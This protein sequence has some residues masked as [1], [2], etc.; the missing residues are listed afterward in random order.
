MD[1]MDIANFAESMLNESVAS[2]KP[3][4]FAAATDPDAPDVSDVDVPANFAS[5]ILLEGHWDKADID[6]GDVVIQESTPAPRLSRKPALVINEESVYKKH[7]LSEYKKKVSDLED[8]IGVMENM[9]MVPSTGSAAVNTTGRIGQG[10]MGGTRR[11]GVDPHPRDR[12]RRRKKA[13]NSDAT[14]RFYN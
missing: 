12:A 10:P 2:G 8:L 3:V 5:Q 4:Q 14:N 9:G 6:V 11:R 13:T 7:L 1:E